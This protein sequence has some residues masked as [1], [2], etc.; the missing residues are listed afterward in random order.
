MTAAY[1]AEGK[2]RIY[3]TAATYKENGEE[4]D[5]KLY[6]VY[7]KVQDLDDS[8]YTLLS[9]TA[10]AS[11]LT[12][13]TSSSASKVGTRLYIDDTIEKTKVAYTYK[14]VIS[15]GTSVASSGYTTG[16]LSA[17]SA[18]VSY[19][20]TPTVKAETYI[21]GTDHAKTSIKI[22]STK[23][24]SD[25]NETLKLYYAVLA[26]DTSS[27]VIAG[28]EWNPLTLTNYDSA[29]GKYYNYLTGQ[30][31]GLYVFKLVASEDGKESSVDYDTV[32]VATKNVSVTAGTLNVSPIYKY[33]ATTNSYDYGTYTDNKCTYYD[34]LSN[35]DTDSFS[36][37]T[38][39]LRKVVITTDKYSNETVVST[40]DLKTLDPPTYSS[41]NYRYETSYP[42]SDV[43]KS[44]SGAYKSVKYYVVKTSKVTGEEARSNVDSGR[45]N[46]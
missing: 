3:W 5:T 45:V 40:D 12:S 43:P 38:F 27:Y 23:N 31:P 9:A 22:T 37:Y 26:E 36:N 21:D 41:T 6:K 18:N 29:A 33:D 42:D 4:I 2:A 1:T 11:E 13:G 10:T 19:V 15:D 34:Y 32:T 25:K 44:T 30:K 14:V 17:Y 39:V 8:T 20:Y 35:S 24:S 46:Y 28:S 7:R 16:Y